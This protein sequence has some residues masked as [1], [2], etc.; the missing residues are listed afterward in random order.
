MARGAVHDAVL[1]ILLA[2]QVAAASIML[3]MRT[4]G[5]AITPAPSYRVALASALGDGEFFFRNGVMKLMNAGVTGG[6][7]VPLRNFDYAALTSWFYL[8]DRLDI[9]S[10]TVPILAAY[11][12]GFTPKTEDSRYIIDY[13]LSRAAQD[14]EHAW[15]WRTQAV[16]FARHRLHDLPLALSIAKAL[17]AD[18]NP[19]APFWTKQMPAFVMLQ[20]GDRQAALIL[21]RSQLDNTPDLNA[22]ERAFLKK[23]IDRLSTSTQQP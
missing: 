1:V 17:A 21:L 20:M 7:V 4:H 16:Y 13:L 15:Q 18:P 6:D 12:Y 14:P 23:S 10:M 3:P 19:N 22:D 11:W 8:L 2:G 5:P 9:R